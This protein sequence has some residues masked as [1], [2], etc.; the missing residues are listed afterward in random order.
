MA[1]MITELEVVP[2]N[3]TPARKMQVQEYKINNF[4]IHSCLT[5]LSR[6]MLGQME[7]QTNNMTGEIVPRDAS[8]LNTGFAAYKA[9]LQFAL[10]HNDPPS[11][12]HEHGYSV[13]IPTQNEIM[14]MPNTKAKMVVQHIDR[15]ASIFYSSDSAN[16]NGNIGKQSEAD[17]VKQT[18]ICED[19][20]A[21]WI[22]GGADN[23]DVGMMIPVFKHLG[24]LQPDV[25]YDKGSIAEPTADRPTSGRPDVPDHAVIGD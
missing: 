15:L 24:E 5:Q 21:L 1:S 10:D 11:G 2:H 19:A 23:N 20:M 13:L 12:A 3:I 4:H 9:T 18:L 7:N 14:K 17:I 25:D 16:T 22:G 8:A 6:L